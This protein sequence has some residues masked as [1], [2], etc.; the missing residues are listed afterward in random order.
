MAIVDVSK[1]PNNSKFDP[2]REAILEL[3]DSILS[4]VAGVSSLNGQT[5][6]VN[7]VAGS[8]ITLSASGGSIT[9]NST[10]TG[11]SLTGELT[12]AAG[13]GIGLSSP[14]IFDGS[15][16]LTVTI[17][18]T[19]RPNDGELTFIAGA[20]LSTATGADWPDE[21]QTWSQQGRVWTVGESNVFSAN[22]SDNVSITLQHDDTSSQASLTNSGGI[23]I[24]SVGLDTFGHVQSM[25]PVNLDNRYL[26]FRT[27]NTED[28]NDSIVATSYNDTITFD[29][30]A[31]ISV[32]KDA[33][34]KKI[35]IGLA[36]SDIRFDNG[37][38]VARGFVYWQEQGQPTSADLPTSS[39]FDFTTGRITIND[40][41]WDQV[42]P[43]TGSAITEYYIARYESRDEGS[44]TSSSR[45]VDYDDPIEATGFEGPVTFNSL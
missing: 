15:T 11:G 34:L 24:Q 4:G 16:D 42:P 21:L 30:S 26:A 36:L 29:G 14:S 39:T 7:I 37:V 20:G 25:V 10:A 45:S 23:V 27:F 32:T 22:T 3:E 2:V 43:L 17:T 13:D 19:D 44:G 18:N 31:S 9:I 33:N 41:S 8:N 28:D 6:A 12:L 40:S 1:I 5:G 35:N 38:R